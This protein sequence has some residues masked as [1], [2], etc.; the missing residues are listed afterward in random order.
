MATEHAPGGEGCAGGTDAAR[1]DARYGDG[2]AP[3]APA[4][5][6][7]DHAADLAPGRALDVAGGAGRHARWLAGRGWDV[8]LVDVSPVGVAL[9]RQRAQ[10]AGVA[11]TTVVRDLA[12]G[13]LPSGPFDLVVVVAFLDRAVLEQVPRVLAPG[14]R[15]LFVHPTVA[16]LDRHDRP[17]RRFLLDPGEISTIADRL[18]LDVEVCGERWSADGHHEACLLARRPV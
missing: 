12:A 4:T 1:W 6:V 17:P 2:D 7:V 5:T 3:R 16:N 18:G 13:P 8:T 15:L 14:G 11:I 9:A 10:E